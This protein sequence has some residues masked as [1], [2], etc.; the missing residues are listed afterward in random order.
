MNCELSRVIILFFKTKIK[1]GG[2]DHNVIRNLPSKT[3]LTLSLM[4]TISKS[5]GYAFVI[6]VSFSYVYQIFN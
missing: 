3:T 4:R 2:G 6:S 5:L 1:G